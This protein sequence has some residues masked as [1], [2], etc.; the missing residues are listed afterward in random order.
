LQSVYRDGTTTV[1]TY[2]GLTLGV[3]I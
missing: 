1:R 2:P 3:R